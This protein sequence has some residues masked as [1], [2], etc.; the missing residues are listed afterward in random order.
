M[1]DAC[2]FRGLRR[3]AGLTGLRFLGAVTKSGPRRME[4][5]RGRDRHPFSTETGAGFS[6]QVS[7]LALADEIGDPDPAQG[8]T[9]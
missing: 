2:D 3:Y 9:S 1:S 7:T 8:A 4:S 5:F 6:D